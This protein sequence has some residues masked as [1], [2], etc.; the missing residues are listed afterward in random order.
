MGAGGE[1][2]QEGGGRVASLPHPAVQGGFQM[3]WL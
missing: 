2:A 1:A 3:I